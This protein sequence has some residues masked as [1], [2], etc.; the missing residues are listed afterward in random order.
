LPLCVKWKSNKQETNSIQIIPEKIHSFALIN[1]IYKK[2]RAVDENDVGGFASNE[3]RKINNQL[4]HQKDGRRRR[5]GV[6]LNFASMFLLVGVV[7]VAMIPRIL[8]R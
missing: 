4:S 6:P 7:G 2:A 8:T 1:A 5:N 3:M